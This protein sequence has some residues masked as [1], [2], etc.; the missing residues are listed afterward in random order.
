MRL[1]SDAELRAL[2]PAE[3]AAFPGPVPTQIVSSDE[4]FPSPQ[5][6]EQARVEARV[7]ALGDELGRK[8]GLSRRAFFRT[9]S[10]MAAA[11]VAMNEVFGHFFDASL[12]EAAHDTERLF[13]NAM[14]TS[15]ATPEQPR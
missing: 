10:G 14:H 3:T 7:K 1:L 2:E 6:A 15:A 9:A 5:S 12:A 13:E 4:Y 11:Y 8:R